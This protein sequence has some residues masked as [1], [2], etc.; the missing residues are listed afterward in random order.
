MSS[1]DGEGAVNLFRN[2]GAREFVRQRHAAQRE[3]SV[4]AGA[5][6]GG[7]AVRRANGEEDARN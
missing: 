3:G 7:P 1:E 6:Y 2:D 5:S 4:G